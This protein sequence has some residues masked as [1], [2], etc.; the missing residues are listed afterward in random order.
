MGSYGLV[1][2]R[3]HD[4]KDSGEYYL[5]FSGVGFQ[6]ALRAHLGLAL[7]PAADADGALPWPS[8][9]IVTMNLGDNSTRHWEYAL[10]QGKRG[11]NLAEEITTVRYAAPRGGDVV[12]PYELDGVTYRIA[13]ESDSE[14]VRSPL[15]VSLMYIPCAAVDIATFPLQAV[16]LYV[17]WVAKAL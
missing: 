6:N 1:V 2:L 17:W 14:E 4:W 13:V 11:N 10:F 12:F 8:Q 7:A 9:R 3:F 15:W 16:G 5:E